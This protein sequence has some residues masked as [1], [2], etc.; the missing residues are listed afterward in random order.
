MKPTARWWSG[1]T[2]SSASGAVGRTSICSR[3]TCSIPT[4]RKLNEREYE[5]AERPIRDLQRLR[6]SRAFTQQEWRLLTQTARDKRAD[7]RL[8]A[9]ALTALWQT[10]DPTQRREVVRLANELL[11]D[12]EPLARAY[13]TNALAV[14]QARQHL[15]Q[16]ERLAANDPD[17]NVRRVAQAAK[18]R[19]RRVFTLLGLE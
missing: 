2:T 10:P 12:P 1:S 6:G 14:L 13:A 15:P 3:R 7:F 16:V 5:K 11:N 9:R 19:T 8:R 17:P 18:V 4:P